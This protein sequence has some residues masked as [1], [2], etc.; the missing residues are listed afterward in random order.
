MPSYIVRNELFRDEVLKFSY[1]F[2]EASD[3]ESDDVYFGTDLFLD[4]IIY[5]KEAAELPLYISK[6]DG[7]SGN[8]GEVK[9]LI[10][11]NRNTVVARATA[12]LERCVATVFNNRDVPVGVFVFHEPGMRRFVGRVAGK[13]ITL[14]N[15]TATFSLDVTSVSE[16]P[17]LRYIG[18]AGQALSGQ[19]RVVARHKTEFKVSD[20]GE[21]SL[22]ILGDAADNTTGLA[23]QVVSV[24]GVRNK[25]IWLAGHPRLNLRIA[26]DGSLQFIV[27]GGAT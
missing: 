6:V 7:T 16:V 23:G 21:V 11:D 3:L 20:T 13:L 8:L 10:S 26:N 15:Q 2:D 14:L 12:G 9:F 19:V 27:A 17:F 5:L 18:V 24:N 25:S 22:N 4:A 1:P